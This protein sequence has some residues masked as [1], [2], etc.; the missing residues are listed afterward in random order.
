MGWVDI[1]VHCF[2]YAH[3]PNASVHQSISEHCYLSLILDH[4]AYTRLIKE[5]LLSVHQKH[6]TF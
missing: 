5:D 3:P 6:Q 1:V 2:L 4:I